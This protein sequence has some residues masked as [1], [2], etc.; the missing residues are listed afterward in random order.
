MGE[1]LNARSILYWRTRLGRAT[2]VR[3]LDVLSA[4]FQPQGWRFVKLYQPT[5]LPLL[6]V[7]ALGAEEVG[8]LVNVLAVLGA[9]I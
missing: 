4:A 7:Y 2:A 3:Y 1:V 5:P 9:V 8:I 6:R